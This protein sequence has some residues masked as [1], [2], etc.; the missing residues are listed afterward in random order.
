MGTFLQ[1]S[2][3]LLVFSPFRRMSSLLFM[4]REGKYG[5]NLVILLIKDA[6]GELNIGHKKTKWQIFSVLF[7]VHF[8][9]MSFSDSPVTKRWEFRKD[10]PTLKCVKY[11]FPILD[12]YLKWRFFIGF[13]KPLIFSLNLIKSVLHF[14]FLWREDQS[15]EKYGKNDFANW[16]DFCGN[17]S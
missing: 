10:L 6:L 1:S 15:L 2:G 14:I 4:L 7:W 3:L 17:L 13:Y 12:P 16:T 11:L 5:T 8:G 9:Q